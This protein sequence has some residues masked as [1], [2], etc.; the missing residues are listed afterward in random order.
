MNV[1]M[2][3]RAAQALTEGIPV[4]LGT[5]SSCP[6]VTQHDM[7]R[8]LVYFSKYVGVTPA[9]ALHTATQVN[10]GLLGLGD[11][12]GTVAAGMDADLVLTR[13]NPLEDLCAPREPLH[14]LVRALL[15]VSLR[16][17]E[18][19]ITR[20]PSPRRG[21]RMKTRRRCARWCAWAHYGKVPT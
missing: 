6:Y 7:W 10:A 3:R 21:G 20:R 19:A 2:M 14:V 1:H 18:R 13:D 9:F 15:A 11:V 4:G 12:C 5:D 17:Y 16:L 8:E